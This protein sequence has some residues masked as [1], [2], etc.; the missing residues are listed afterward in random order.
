VSFKFEITNNASALI[1][2]IGGKIHSSED[3]EGLLT[4]LERELKNQKKQFLFE[5]SNL[6]YITSTGLN[7]F[8]RSLTRIRNAGGELVVC[9]MH[10][11]VE[12]LFKISK[13][14]EIF[15]ICPTV[16]EG[17]IKINAQQA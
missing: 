15:I 12:K 14:N 5:V 9:N 7:F 8:I 2:S 3:T 17:L 13:L 10:G 11:T 16:E 1:F 6:E 4:Q